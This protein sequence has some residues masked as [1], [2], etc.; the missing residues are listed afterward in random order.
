MDLARSQTASQE[1][2]EGIARAKNFGELNEGI[3]TAKMD[4]R[5]EV[6]MKP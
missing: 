6:Q 4:E 3:P 5:K 1:D 2:S